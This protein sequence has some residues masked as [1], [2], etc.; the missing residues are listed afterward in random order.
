MSE[1][2]GI[3]VQAIH[4]AHLNTLQARKLVAGSDDP[5]GEGAHRELQQAVAT[6]FETLRPH[7]TQSEE[8]RKYYHGKVPESET[9]DGV[10]ILGRTMY[11]EQ[12]PYES[13]KKPPERMNPQE[14]HEYLL[15]QVPTKEN[16][17]AVDITKLG[18]EVTVV[19]QQ[20]TLGLKHL[21]G[22]YSNRETVTIERDEWLPE[23]DPVQQQQLEL[24]DLDMLMAASR[25]L[26]EA[27]HSLGFLPKD[28]KREKNEFAAD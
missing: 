10:A 26:D 24:M 21:E 27:A 16:E 9:G 17:L 18:D 15:K 19:Y 5:T 14:R 2:S 8:G 28:D 6:Y 23:S 20:F 4:E 12:Y 11:Q 13:F 22:L 3:P 25:A 7:L 1:Q